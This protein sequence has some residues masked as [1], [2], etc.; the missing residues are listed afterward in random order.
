[1]KPNHLTL[2]TRRIMKAA[3]YRRDPD[4]AAGRERAE[5][6]RDAWCT[7]KGVFELDDVPP[8]ARPV[9]SAAAWHKAHQATNGGGDDA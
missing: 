2:E 6:Q 7:W 3:D 9:A 4:A 1:M 8:H 5:A